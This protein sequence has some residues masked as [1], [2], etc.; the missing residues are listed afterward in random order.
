M[1]GEQSKNGAQNNEQFFKE[2]RKQS[3][4]KRTNQ[5]TSIKPVD[6]CT[7]CYEFLKS[8]GIDCPKDCDYTQAQKIM[9]KL[10]L[11]NHPDK[12]SEDT[13]KYTEIFSNLSNCNDLIIKEKCM[14]KD[15]YAKK[16]FTYEE[17]KKDSLEKRE[18]TVKKSP[19]KSPKKTIAQIKKECK[20]KGLVYDV[21][22]KKCRESKRGKRKSPKNFGEK[23]KARR[24][25]KGAGKKCPPGTVLSPSGRCIKIGGVAYKKYF[26]E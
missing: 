4:N 18:K 11:N 5:N 26:G 19:K 23:S 16:Q 6:D 13:K 3:P 8:Y 10:M 7:K 20:E 12:H 1:G 22:T 2:Y 24:I 14:N 9:R 21:G 17:S 25:G 15:L